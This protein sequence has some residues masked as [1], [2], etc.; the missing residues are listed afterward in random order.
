MPVTKQ[1]PMAMPSARP[2]RAVTAVDLSVLLNLGHQG[3][4]GLAR[5]LGMLISVA[6]ICDDD[7]YGTPTSV[8]QKR[9]FGPKALVQSSGDSADPPDRD[10]H[11][12]HCQDEEDPRLD[13]LE[14][15]ETLGGLIELPVVRARPGADSRA[16][17]DS[18]ES[19]RIRRTRN[20]R[21]GRDHPARGIADAGRQDPAAPILVGHPNARQLFREAS[22]NRIGVLLQRTLAD[23]SVQAGT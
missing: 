21:V 5:L 11:Q 7:A 4:L 16:A 17:V 14:R 10:V 12:R 20:L 3:G 1:I 18:S 8:C 22:P 2:S 15:P 23:Q 9:R 6:G 19:G 13:A